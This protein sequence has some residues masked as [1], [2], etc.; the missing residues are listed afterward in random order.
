MSSYSGLLLL[1]QERDSNIIEIDRRVERVVEEQ[2]VML[3]DTQDGASTLRIDLDR[4]Y[5]KETCLNV[6]K[7]EVFSVSNMSVAIQN[8]LTVEISKSNVV[9]EWDPIRFQCQRKVQDFSSNVTPDGLEVDCTGYTIM[10]DGPQTLP[11]AER[12]ES[13]GR[14]KY[15]EIDPPNAVLRGRDPD[16]SELTHLTPVHG[17]CVFEHCPVYCTHY[18]IDCLQ[19][20]EDDA[21]G[22][23]FVPLMARS[24][25]A[26]PLH[27]TFELCKEKVASNCPKQFFWYYGCDNQTILSDEMIP[28]ID[29]D[30]CVYSHPADVA[31]DSPFYSSQEEAENSCDGKPHE[32]TCYSERERQHWFP[33]TFDLDRKKCE[34][35]NPPTCIDPQQ[36]ACDGKTDYYTPINPMHNEVTGVFTKNYLKETEDDE[37]LDQQDG[38]VKCIEPIPG[39]RII[40]RMLSEDC[41][42]TCF[43][44]VGSQAAD[45]AARKGGVVNVGNDTCTIEDCFMTSQQKFPDECAPEYYYQ[46]DSTNTI[47]EFPKTAFIDGVNEC[48]YRLPP[49][50]LRGPSFNSRAEAE[51]NCAGQDVVRAC[52]H[53]DPNNN[54]ILR[55][56]ELERTNCSYN[57]LYGPCLETVA[58]G[59]ACTGSTNFYKVATDLRIQ[60]GN[61]Y[62]NVEST[63]VDNSYQKKPGTDDY[64]CVPGGVPPGFVMNPVCTGGCY[65]VGGGD[66]ME[67][68]RGGVFN[69][70]KTLCTIEGCYSEPQGE[71]ES[72]STCPGTTTYYALGEERYTPDGRVQDVVSTSVP[73]RLVTQD[74]S[75]DEALG[76]WSYDQNGN[77]VRRAPCVPE[78]C[79][80]GD[81]PAGY[82]D[83]LSEVECA[84]Y[85]YTPSSGY[86]R[87]FVN[88]AVDSAACTINP[89]YNEPFSGECTGSTKY[90]RLGPRTWTDT[91]AEFPIETLDKPYS[92]NTST[93]Q[94]EP[95]N[96]PAGYV[97]ET[98]PLACEVACYTAQGANILRQQTGA[99]VD[100]KCIID[101]CHE[102]ERAPGSDPCEGQSDTYYA[103]AGTFASVAGQPTRKTVGMTTS[104]K[105]KI[106]RNGTCVEQ[107]PPSG[108]DTLASTCKTE[109]IDNV[110][111]SST[112]E[113]IA[114]TGTMGEGDMC[115]LDGCHS[116]DGG[117]DVEYSVSSDG[118]VYRSGSSPTV[119][120]GPDCV[121]GSW[122]QWSPVDTAGGDYWQE[123]VNYDLGG[124]SLSEI[125]GDLSLCK[126]T[127][128]KDDAC[129]GF[130]RR[131]DQCWFKSHFEGIHS[132]DG[133]TT[134][135]SKPKGRDLPRM[136]DRTVTGTCSPSD[137]N[138]VDIAF[139]RNITKRDEW[140]SCS[141]DTQCWPTSYENT[142]IQCYRTGVG[143]TSG[144][145]RCLTDG[146]AKWACELPDNGG[147]WE[148]GECTDPCKATTDPAYRLGSFTRASGQTSRVTAPF[149]TTTVPRVTGPDGTCTSGA[150][151]SGYAID[152][153]TLSCEVKASDSMCFDQ[154]GNAIAATGRIDTAANACVVDDCYAN[155]S[156]DTDRYYTLDPASFEPKTG[157]DLQQH[158]GRKT[159][160]IE[161]VDVPRVRDASG[162]CRASDNVPAGYQDSVSGVGCAVTAQ[163]QVCTASRTSTA[164][165]AATGSMNV[166]GDTCT[167]ENCYDYDPLHACDYELC[168]SK[169]KEY[170]MKA[171]RLNTDDLGLECSGC[172]KRS[173]EG[174]GM[175]S[176]K[177]ARGDVWTSGTMPKRMWEDV[178][179]Y[180][181][182]K[183]H[184][185]AVWEPT[186]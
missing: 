59:E 55:T 144:N 75:E 133:S 119:V 49:T 26:E 70:G 180:L 23:K 68:A 11:V 101:D 161:S 67:S 48:G 46:Y 4:E 116:G 179:N 102:S 37:L 91:T 78:S 57:G 25:C 115:V 109:A 99:I 28:R 143:Q 19:I 29:G 155:C 152:A 89:C 105:P 112:G 98:T 82:A 175:H 124:D 77:L 15:L 79:V 111:Y 40:E 16:Q 74:C 167:L 138:T 140:V 113:R 154:V 174:V 85:C 10:C 14:P 45:P 5:D 169:I 50:T 185:S 83:R 131:G 166:A 182:L 20:I 93:N 13:V 177:F 21:A 65:T 156:V 108:Y 69:A 41:S 128:G 51:A 120:D 129:K 121:R 159:A 42:E 136:R 137:D 24:N 94:C 170:A 12:K 134:Y 122:G 30:R 106:N 127:C 125:T 171:W 36:V 176:L 149:Q 44:G 7:Y 172:P 54:Y 53:L 110:C 158:D 1:Q 34:Y 96:A 80:D 86:N 181:S 3:Y 117:E 60:N 183:R 146:G 58:D 72:A 27:N 148:N 90:H 18:D 32:Y 63:V 71:V 165:V 157:F 43:S 123:Y 141:S 62:R 95:G 186:S 142:P 66:T 84:A 162:V 103:L 100:G 147:V 114:V 151:P 33:E 145:G 17:E 97:E 31:T 173:L 160:A 47:V 56:H 76:D 87:V 38:S 52:Y 132:K 153:T 184:T 135:I 35:R 150:M 64:E 22:P 107:A 126:S 163:D 8:G 164:A 88:G 104:V 118:D 168:D 2:E 9:G 73:D 61:G 178:Y 139:D 6:P 81:R 130:T 39:D 92:F